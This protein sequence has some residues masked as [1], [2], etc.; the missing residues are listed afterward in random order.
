[1]LQL[2]SFGTCLLQIGRQML[3]C[4]GT[5]G[6]ELLECTPLFFRLCLVCA[7]SL[8]LLGLRHNELTELCDQACILVL[9]LHK[10][11]HSPVKGC[12]GLFHLFALALELLM[13]H[14][15]LCVCFFEV[16]HNLLLFF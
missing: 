8:E 11:F 14:F 6:T 16:S 12:L 5:V 3:E 4:F 13:Q 10:R 2:I 1:M 15:H 9:G 7:R